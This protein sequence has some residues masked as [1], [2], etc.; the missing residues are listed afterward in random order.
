MRENCAAWSLRTERL[1]VTPDWNGMLAEVPPRATNLRLTDVE[2]YLTLQCV[3]RAI[4][5]GDAVEDW[6]SAPYL[7][8]FMESYS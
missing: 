8:N 2:H 7:L 6:K 1:A 4:D 3:S 5:C